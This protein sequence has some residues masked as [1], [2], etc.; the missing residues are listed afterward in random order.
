MK[1][2]SLILLFLGSL[3]LVAGLTEQRV[4]KRK[5]KIIYKYLPKS[6][7]DTQFETYDFKKSMPAIFDEDVT[8]F[9]R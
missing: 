3:M 9:Y 8:S 4:K 1:S 6:I 2:I 7:Y 5:N